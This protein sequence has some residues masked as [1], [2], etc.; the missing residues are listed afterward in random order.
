MIVAMPLPRSAMP[1]RGVGKGLMPGA[2]DVGMLV[3]LGPSPD[4]DEAGVG[5]SVSVSD[6]LLGSALV[7][8][9][10]ASA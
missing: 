2:E 6:P 1:P 9:V 4:A 8:L 10:G 7:A 3:A 5:L